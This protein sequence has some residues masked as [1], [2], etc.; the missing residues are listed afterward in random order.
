RWTA[1][2]YLSTFPAAL[3]LLLPTEA[4]RQEVRTLTHAR[5]RLN[6][7]DV[8]GLV[9]RLR[10]RAPRQAELLEYLARTGG[11]ADRVQ[12]LAD[13]GESIAGPIR[14]ALQKGWLAEGRVVRRRDPFAD[15][16]VV[17][18]PPPVLTPE[19]EQALESIR[20]ELLAPPAFRP[21]V[22]IHGVT[23]SGKT[24][25]YLRAIA[26][27]REMGRNAICLVPEISLTPQMIQ[28]FRAR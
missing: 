25:L 17:P 19:Q 21:P 7:D 6:V 12:I 10:A 8:E 20:Q 2:R 3:R 14:A 23:G 18:A 15:E 13:L 26:L 9:A 4:R 24:E 11:E 27:V 5:Y 28:R 22:L 1:D 16:Q